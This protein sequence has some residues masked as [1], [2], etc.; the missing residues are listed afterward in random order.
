MK[1]ISF[2]ILIISLLLV[3]FY[4]I[5]AETINAIDIDNLY[6]EI[7]GRSKTTIDLHFTTFEEL[8]N[9]E[10]WIYSNL[11]DGGDRETTVS[12]W[13]FCANRV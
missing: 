10:I 3:P 9:L 6:V 11:N 1:K 2:M 8:E 13:F 12:A 7:S 4:N 5:E